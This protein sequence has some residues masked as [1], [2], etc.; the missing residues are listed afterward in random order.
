M[1]GF[2]YIEG[3]G[4]QISEN[5]QSFV[6]TSNTEEARNPISTK[7]LWGEGGLKK[8]LKKLVTSLG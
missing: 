2:P 7:G 6:E 1:G 3:V 4:G 8:S 5:L